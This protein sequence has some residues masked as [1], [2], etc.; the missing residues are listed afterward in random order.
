[1]PRRHSSAQDFELVGMDRDPTPGDLDLIQG[2]ITR[3]RDVADAAE[4]AL[5]ILKRDGDISRGRGDTIDALNEKIGDDLPDKLRKTAASYHDAAQ[6]YTDYVPRLR[7]AQETFDRAVDQAAA[8][9][10]QAGL[11]PMTLTD[12]STDED[13]AAARRRQDDIEAGQSGL[14]AAKG[15]AQQARQM[16]ESA[17]R[18]C[19]DVLDRAAS[20]AIPE[21]SI[22]QKIRDFFADFPFVKILLGILIA[23]VAVFFPVAGVLL[24]GALFAL[25]QITAIATGNFSLGEFAVG[26]FGIVPGGGLLKGGAAVVAKFAPKIAHSAGGTLKGIKATFGSTKTVGGPLN[27]SAGT[28]VGKAADEFASSAAEEAASQAVSGDPIDVGGILGAG[29]LGLV[30]GGLAA[31]A[32]RKT[33]PIPFKGTARPG[34]TGG[35]RAA[36]GGAAPAPGRSA[37][38]GSASAT[39]PPAT[40]LTVAPHGQLSGVGTP[41]NAAGTGIDLTRHE[42]AGGHTVARHVGRTIP[43]LQARN[44]PTAST[45]TDLAAAERATSANLVANQAAIS[46]FVRGRATRLV[47]HDRINPADGTVFRRSTGMTTQPLSITTVLQKDPTALG[48]FRIVTSFPE[49]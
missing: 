7:E 29:A 26:L 33:P 39:V 6:A 38:A 5:N 30:G 36:P 18:Q 22:F 23:V 12:T 37:S 11:S 21:R 8:A 10:P 40:G 9:A 19:A 27:G 4:K 13:K 47:I 45:F 44:I 14:S 48:G 28:V 46:A 16:R 31:G 25:D 3:Y 20:E 49:P 41:L 43:Q 35:T 1:M 42:N 32:G 15:L 17:Q 2:V 34:G 24:G